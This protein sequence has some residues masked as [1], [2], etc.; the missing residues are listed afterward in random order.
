MQIG[1]GTTGGLQPLNTTSDGERGSDGRAGDRKAAQRSRDRK[2]HRR[3][4]PAEPRIAVEKTTD[5]VL[6]RL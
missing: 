6:L 2:H 4:G 3:N 5:G 1:R